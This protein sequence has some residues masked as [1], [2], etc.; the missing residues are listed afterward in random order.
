MADA[1]KAPEQP[2]PVKT[3]DGRA[4]RVY[5]NK[6]QERVT[7]KI[8]DGDPIEFDAYASI[9]LAHKLMTAG[10]ATRKGT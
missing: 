1:A 5:G 2:V 9:H 3:R 10:R 6:R 8:G 7:I 4:V